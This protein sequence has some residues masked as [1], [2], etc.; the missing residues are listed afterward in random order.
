MLLNTSL[1]YTT[2]PIAHGQRDTKP[3][4][5]PPSCRTSVPATLLADWQTVK[6]F[7]HTFTAATEPRPDWRRWHASKSLSTLMR[8]KTLNLAKEWQ[9][10]HGRRQYSHIGTGNTSKI[11]LQQR[12]VVTDTLGVCV[13]VQQANRAAVLHN[14]TIRDYWEEQ[15]IW[16]NPQDEQD[17]TR[18]YLLL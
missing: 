1:E 5:Y 16:P 8:L 6:Q 4:G 15:P 3:S 12:Q 2:K 18:Y 7:D 9:T 13:R 17:L 10:W 11:L 14:N